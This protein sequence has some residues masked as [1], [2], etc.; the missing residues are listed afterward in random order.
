MTDLVSPSLKDRTRIRVILFKTIW[1]MRTPFYRWFLACVSRSS[2]ISL[3]CLF[4][5]FLSILSP[6]KVS[7][8]VLENFDKG[9]I[10]HTPWRIRIQGGCWKKYSWVAVKQCL[11]NWV[12]TKVYIS[13]RH[14][15]NQR[16]EFISFLRGSGSGSRDPHLG[17][18]DPEPG[19]TLGKS[20]CGSG[21]KVDP[22]PDSG[23]LRVPYLPYF[24]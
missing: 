7:G 21:F 11:F 4:F 5:N 6:D 15:C 9:C 18:V 2:Q 1:L 19:S 3:F 14:S 10:T 23:V 8:E 16:F 22:D 12:L 17:K 20:G 13:S 24:V